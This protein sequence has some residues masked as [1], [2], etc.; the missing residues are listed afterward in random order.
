MLTQQDVKSLFD[1]DPKTGICTWKVHRL[2]A[3]P[4]DP[5][6]ERYVYRDG[7]IVISVKGKAQMLHRLIHLWMTGEH[8][9]QQIDHIDGDK[10]NN[11]WENLRD[12]SQYENLC[13]KEHVEAKRKNPAPRGVR[14]ESKNSWSATVTVD[15]KKLHI[16]RFD[17]VEKAEQAYLQAV[18]LFHGQLPKNAS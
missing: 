11:R 14:K 12:V 13:N 4:G 3:G 17:S 8:P 5:I 1:Y 2:K 9:K 10:L 7:Y 15:G 6:D 18:V 16:G